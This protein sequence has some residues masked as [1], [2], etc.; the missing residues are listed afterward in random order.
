MP[1][2]DLLRQVRQ[3]SLR[4]GVTLIPVLLAVLSSMSGTTELKYKPWIEKDWTKWDRRDCNIILNS[5]PWVYFYGT[6]K[7]GSAQGYNGEMPGEAEYWTKIQFRSALPIR[8]VLLRQLQLE[9]RYDKMRPQDKQEFDS[10]H[11]TDLVVTDEDPIVVYIENGA[12]NAPPLAGSGGTD[13]LPSAIR[14]RQVALKLAN[15]KVLTPI[16]TIVLKNDVN[17]NQYE[18]FFPRNVDGKPVI[19]ANDPEISVLLGDIISFDNK[20]KEL[21]PLKPEEFHQFAEPMHFL[22]SSLMYKGKLEY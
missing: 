11:A 13:R 9:K 17:K 1:P 8:Q 22:V 14:P 3:V 19:T 6:G 4:F 15:G 18:C 12:N 10:F 5:S 16:K 20:H 7:L 21:G 2:I